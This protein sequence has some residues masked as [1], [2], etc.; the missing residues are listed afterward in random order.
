MNDMNPSSHTAHS[1]AEVE[2]QG[3]AIVFATNNSHKLDEIRAIL[4]DR[5]QILGLSEMG[6]RATPSR[7]HAT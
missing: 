1:A 3:R 5:L 6:W 2:Q 4:G 7:R